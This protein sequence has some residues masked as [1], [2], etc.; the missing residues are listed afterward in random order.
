V[1][2]ISDIILEIIFK[3]NIQMSVDLILKPYKLRSFKDGINFF[4]VDFSADFYKDDHNPKFQ[5]YLDILNYRLISLE[6]Y[7]ILHEDKQ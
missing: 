2:K 1:R 3:R 7:N 5:F 6:I 4:F